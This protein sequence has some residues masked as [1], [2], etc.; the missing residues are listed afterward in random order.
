MFCLLCCIGLISPLGVMGSSLLK[1]I[2]CL[3]VLD[4]SMAFFSPIP[5]LKSFRKSFLASKCLIKMEYPIP[6]SL[7]PEQLD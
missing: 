6:F 5:S 4:A 3:T 1:V 2:W 7:N